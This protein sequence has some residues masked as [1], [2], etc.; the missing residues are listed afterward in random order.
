MKNQYFNSLLKP[1]FSNLWTENLT[2][3]TPSELS[4]LDRNFS[5]VIDKISSLSSQ[6]KVDGETQAIL[7]AIENGTFFQDPV[8]FK[9]NF[10]QRF[11]VHFSF[12][13][14]DSVSCGVYFHIDDFNE[15]LPASRKKDF[16]PFF[17]NS[18]KSKNEIL[19]DLAKGNIRSLLSESPILTNDLKYCS[20]PSVFHHHVSSLAFGHFLVFL[21]RDL[22]AIDNFDEEIRKYLLVRQK[23]SFYQIDLLEAVGIRRFLENNPDFKNKFQ[24]ILEIFSNQNKDGK[25]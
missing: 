4:I 19:P 13:K 1:G 12:S 3:L 2:H 16:A 20:F 23:G 5:Q 17:S 9:N 24:V 15:L 18:M 6:S 8:I 7:T 14:R 10:I 22:N 11:C 21:L 25:L